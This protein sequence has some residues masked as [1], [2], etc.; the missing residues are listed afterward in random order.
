M[1]SSPAFPSDPARPTPFERAVAAVATADDQRAV[2]ALEPGF[3][4]VGNTT[5]T[6][7][8]VLMAHPGPGQRLAAP[9][10]ARVKAMVKVA[11]EP[12]T[13]VVVGGAPGDRAGLEKVT[14]LYVQRRPLLAHL[15]DGALP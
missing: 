1:S 12:L 14:P 13:V 11:A 2:L 15:P 7:R 6:Q 9:L 10:V 4:I 3:A 8:V 5:S